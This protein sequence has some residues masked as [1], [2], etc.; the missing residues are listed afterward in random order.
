MLKTFSKIIIKRTLNW[1]GIDLRSFNSKPNL[2]C[3]QLSPHLNFAFF[4]KNKK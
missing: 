2:S 4:K 3:A 1:V